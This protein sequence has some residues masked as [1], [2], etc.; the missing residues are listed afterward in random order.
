MASA[1]EVGGRISNRGRARDVGLGTTPCSDCASGTASEELLQSS[2][3]QSGWQRAEGRGEG[4]GKYSHL[5]SA[6]PSR[7]CVVRS[8]WRGRGGLEEGGVKLAVIADAHWVF[9]RNF[10]CSSKPAPMAQRRALCHFRWGGQRRGGTEVT[11]LS[12]ELRFYTGSP[13]GMCSLNV[14]LKQQDSQQQGGF[15]RL[16]AQRDRIRGQSVKK[17]GRVSRD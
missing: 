11:R 9:V 10:T 7:S 4:T 15:N 1:G 3:P 5:G 14:T 16:A 13:T 2:R 8:K 17:E 6:D 12:G